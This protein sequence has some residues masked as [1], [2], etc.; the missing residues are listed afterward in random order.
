L[1]TF[2]KLIFKID[3]N[4]DSTYLR[5]LILRRCAITQTDNDKIVRITTILLG[6]LSL[7]IPFIVFFKTMAPTLSF[8]DCGEFIACAKTL[9]IPHPPGTPFFVVIGRLFII[10]GLFKNVAMRTN[11]IS[12][13]SSSLTIFLV[14]LTIIRVSQKLP[15]NK[16]INPQLGQIG[17]RIG[18]F[19]AGLLLA[20]S[21]TFW[22]NAVETEVY[23][24]AMLLM[25][26]LI[27][28]TIR[29]GEDKETGG[30]DKLLVFITYLLFFSVSIHLTTFLIV[31]ALFLY[32]IWID[33]EKLKD[34]MFWVT[35]AI[36]F[37]LALPVWFLIGMAIPWVD[38][39]SYWIWIV[40][41]IV[42]AIFTG[43][44]AYKFK[45]AGGR[46]GLINYSLAF[47]LFL[48]AIVGYSTH[49]YIPIRAS[50]HPMINE[51]DPS[52]FS[53]FESYIERKQYGQES[54][55]TRMLSRRGSLAHQFGMYANM[56]MGGYLWGQFSSITP[57]GHT[58]DFKNERWGNT[59]DTLIFLLGTFG[60]L[61]GFYF[62]IKKYKQHPMILI[63]MIFFISTVLLCLYLNFSDGTRADPMSPGD[64]I[65]LEV[66]ERDYFYTPA[67]VV[68]AVMIGVGMAAVMRL[69]GENLR[70][71]KNGQDNLFRYLAFSAV[72]VIFL[73]M[74]LNPLNAHYREHD[75]SKDFAPA[76]YAYNILQS[77]KPNGIIFT[78]GDNDTFPL[79]YLQEVERVRN[80]VRVVNLSLL[81]TDWYILQLKHQMGVNM[82]LED[83]QIAWIP[84]D[85]RGSIIYYRPKEKFM[86][87]VRKR[88]RYLTAEQDQRT[89]AV[90][91]VQD[92]MIEQIVIAN[93]DK[94]PIYFS[95]SVPNS[96][97]WTLDNRL[98]RQG[99][100]LQV[101]PDT[102]KPRIDLA[103]TDSL[104][105]KIYQYR[106]LNDVMAFKDENNVGL[107][108]TFPERFSELSDA[109]KADGDTTRALQLLWYSAD[110]L[111]YYH[112]TY[113]DLIDTYKQNN[114][115]VMADSAKAVG[116]RNL[117][118]VCDVWP[119]I[120]LY[121]Q[122]LGVLY[123]H[124][125]MLNEALD[126]YRTA[127]KLQPD[128]SIAFRLLRDLSMHMGKNDEARALMIDWTRRHPEDLEIQNQLNR[129]R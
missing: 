4:D 16:S 15:F 23:G 29:W 108:T 82:Y 69:L 106:G 127:Y 129:M 98:I 113:M 38:D 77:C 99:I 73:L 55:I 3:K 46:S 76:D 25:V 85:H 53:S 34:P 45:A 90:M 22:F 117:K 59:I 49:L 62:A 107:T 88:M 14:Y 33:R 121:H 37:S 122:F 44:K 35:W 97:R 43:L 92:Q 64:V 54:M 86:D 12:V 111:P 51:N 116:I 6:A 115:S 9:G 11:F 28:L 87:T 19:S 8:W 2:L 91:R 36:F 13:I 42:G 81:N 120:I 39:K 124:A 79:W 126:R 102:T 58:D 20:F 93:I 94:V 100:V 128:N 52:S 89:G 109:Y 26:L 71:G 110:R 47:A 67:F 1:G 48:A 50:Q 101:D 75:R 112:Q 5:S 63:F 32:F 80:D 78:N 30:S 40:L 27:Y 118:N 31:P 57:N 10:L 105:T 66:R 56:G 41:M 18:A 114:N 61:V 119:D 104:I 96:N 83:N 65:P 103:L 74:P 21:G 70:Y 24:A 60:T 68:F 125:N 72:G 17:V 123:F 7:I 95:G 84:A